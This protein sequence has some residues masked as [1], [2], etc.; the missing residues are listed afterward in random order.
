[1]KVQECRCRC[2]SGEGEG[3]VGGL[4]AGFGGAETS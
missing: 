1:M 4:V 3:A 2:R